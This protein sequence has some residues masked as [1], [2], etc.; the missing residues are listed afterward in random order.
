MF[1]KINHMA[2]RIPK[3]QFIRW[4]LFHYGRLAFW[5]PEAYPDFLSIGAARAGTTW[6][7]A[8]LSQHP[9]IY[10]PRSK[11]MHFFDVAPH[12][13]PL[14]IEYDLSKES[15]WRWYYMVY[16]GK[17]NLI[18]GD[19]TPAYMLLSEER[20]RAIKKKMPNVRIILIIRNPIDRAWSGL[21]RG[22]WFRNAKRPSDIGTSNDLRPVLM[23]PEILDRGDYISSIKKWEK[24]VPE[25]RIM[26]VFFEDLFKKP[27]PYLSE[28]CKF[29]GVDAAGLPNSWDENAKINAAPPD[30]IPA[31]LHDELRKLYRKQISFLEQKFS[32]NLSHWLSDRY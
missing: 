13:K 27:R 5:I 15:H 7:H 16:G 1:S 9:Q 20:I 4:I 26:Y 32:R 10:L 31:V 29:L 22:L 3:T 24:H 6:L 25:D 2:R 8:R 19:V 30:P 21:R 17:G 11:E 18:K 28:I 14:R 23:T 12:D